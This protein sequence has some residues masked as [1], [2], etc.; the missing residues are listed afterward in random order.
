[1]AIAHTGQAITEE[2]RQL[3]QTMRAAFLHNIGDIRLEEIRIPTLD[4]ADQ[5]LVQIKAVGICGS[6]LHYYEKGRIGTAI[7]REPLI[8]GHEAAG[9]VVEVGAQVTDLQ[10]GDRVAIEP[11][12]TCRRCEF[13]K[14][15][16]YNLC[17]DVIFLGTPP[18][19]GAF[20]EYLAWPADFLFKLPEQMSYEEGAMLEPLAVGMH[21]ARLAQ[22]SPGDSVAVLGAGPIGL[23]SLQAAAAAGATLT[24]ATDVIPYRLRVARQLGATYT[25]D[26]NT[27]V[28]E[29][30]MELTEGR[31]VDVV[32]DCVGLAETTRQAIAMVRR[33]GHIQAV[34]L[35]QDSIDQ[36]PLFD[37]INKE[38]SLAGTFRYANRHPSA[39][40]TVV[41]GKVDVKSLITHRFPL[42]EIPEAMAWVVENKHQVIKAIIQFGETNTNEEAN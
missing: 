16:R 6:D 26:A 15:G 38:V 22:I 17:P 24:I 32:I 34:G 25:L 14:S 31:G 5:A 12:R 9:Q 29:V 42:A 23:V 33:G 2:V 35:A 10:P 11:G 20:C 1:M 7:V 36:F 37:I 18:V 41:A 4:S 3:A 40:A 19:H 30:V 13:C 39:I 8:L 27:D 28:V 21:A